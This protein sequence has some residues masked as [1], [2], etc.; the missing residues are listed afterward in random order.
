MESPFM[1]AFASG[2]AR[3]GLRIMR[4]EFPYMRSARALGRRK[5]PD[6]APVLLESWH[7]AIAMARSQGAQTLSIGG[8]S[9]GGRM[10]SLIADEAQVEALIC[11]GYPFHPP[12]K[13]ERL[14]TE[15]LASLGTRTLICQGERDTFGRREEVAAYA[16]SDAID[17]RWLTDGDHSFK[18]RKAS[19]RTEIQNWCEA[20][21]A[22][23][24]FLTGS[25]DEAATMER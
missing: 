12:G 9:M 7:Q 15:H 11:L 18:P 23:A 19:G 13:P 14:R 24:G 2:L 4:F 10:A 3:R 25:Q 1:A 16:L 21:D 22:V 17:L 5:P 8:K 20:M 6:R